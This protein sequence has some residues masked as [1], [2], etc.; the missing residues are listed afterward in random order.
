[1]NENIKMVQRIKCHN[2]WLFI[3]KLLIVSIFIFS[4]FTAGCGNIDHSVDDDAIIEKTCGELNTGK[5]ILVAY[6]T[7]HSS[8]AGI[9]DHISNE[10]CGLN[11]R[12]DL[13]YVENVLSYMPVLRLRC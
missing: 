1:M 2:S 5:D 6:A 9:A 7:R 8:T 11:H 3:N 4:L 13:R 10:L 12:V